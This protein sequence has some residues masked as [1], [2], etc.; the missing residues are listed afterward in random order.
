MLLLS[1]A[2]L[3]ASGLS[4]GTLWTACLAVRDVG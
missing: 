1:S 4:V 3:L 2:V